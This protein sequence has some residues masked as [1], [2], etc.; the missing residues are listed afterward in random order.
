MK[1][2]ENFSLPKGILPGPTDWI[3]CAKII[4]EKSQKC[5]LIFVSDHKGSTPRETGAWLLVSNSMNIGTLGGGEIERSAILAA[6]GMLRGEEKFERC[7]K[8]FSLGPD[9][10]QCC[11]GAMTALFEPVDKIALNWLSKAEQLIISEN[12]GHVF[13]PVQDPELPP[14]IHQTPITK[15][16]PKFSRGHIQK[17]FDP[18]PQ[19]IIYGAGHVGRAVA[20]VSASLPVR[21]FI[22]DERKHELNQVPAGNNIETVFCEN[23]VE[24]ARQLAGCDAVVIMTHSHGLDFRLCDILLENDPLTYLGLI[25]SKTKATRFRKGLKSGGKSQQQISSLTCPIGIQ[26]PDGKEP[27]II[28]LS[29]L[30]EILKRLQSAKNKRNGGS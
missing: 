24:H 19:I 7:V 12:Q 5:I 14:E 4:L 21:L 6:Q 8:S 23:P 9:L 30:S 15:K 29:V 2:K 26:G 18:R 17:L 20:S 3:A 16:L 13:F 27:G 28:A 25:G 1:V 11:G 10:G 22:V